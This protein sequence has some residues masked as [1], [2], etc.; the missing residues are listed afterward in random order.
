VKASAEGKSADYP[1]AV[2]GGH[3]A[4][5]PVTGGCGLALGQL[6]SSASISVV[7]D[8]GENV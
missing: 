4:D 5:I 8:L 2:F 1:V 6:L 7:L 3:K